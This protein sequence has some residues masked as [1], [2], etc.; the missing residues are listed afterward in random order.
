M[1]ENIN[2]KENNIFQ[3]CYLPK[4]QEEENK[5]IDYPILYGY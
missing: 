4:T 5:K 1:E 3:K 2:N